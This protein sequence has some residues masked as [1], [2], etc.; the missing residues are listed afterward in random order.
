MYLDNEYYKLDSIQVTPRC[1]PTP[2]AHVSGS[3]WHLPRP[4]HL[5]GEEPLPCHHSCS[6]YRGSAHLQMNSDLSASLAL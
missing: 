2:Y 6:Q 3:E 1:S 5:L 4:A